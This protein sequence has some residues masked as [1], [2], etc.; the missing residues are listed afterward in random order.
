MELKED[1]RVSYP[2]V[3]MAEHFRHQAEG[4]LARLTTEPEAVAR[5]IGQQGWARDLEI[6]GVP[7]PELDEVQSLFERAGEALDAGDPEGAA[8]LLVDLIA[9]CTPDE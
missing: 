7:Q 6:V 4:Y 8:G 1:W 2:G 9:Y 5:D 3:T